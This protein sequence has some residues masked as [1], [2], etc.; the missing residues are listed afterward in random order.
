MSDLFKSAFGYFSSSS[1][2]GQ[3]NELLGQVVEIGNV[4]LRVKK[5]IAEGKLSYLN[6]ISCAILAVCV[7]LG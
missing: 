6:R 4:K 3:G 5:V 7:R 1:T 2:G